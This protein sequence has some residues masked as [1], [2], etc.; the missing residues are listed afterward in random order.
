MTLYRCPPRILNIVSILL[1]LILS[2][3]HETEELPPCPERYIYD[4]EYITLDD[5]SVITGKPIYRCNWN[6]SI[7]I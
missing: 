1:I 4:Y 6:P 5:G 3:C 7:N 2:G